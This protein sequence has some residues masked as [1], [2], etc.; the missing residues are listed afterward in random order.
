L[1]TDY[2]NFPK[3]GGKDLQTAATFAQ[4]KKEGGGTA[5]AATTTTSASIPIGISSP[6]LK[7]EIK[8]ELPTVSTTPKPQALP[9][10]QPL[11]F[12]KVNTANNRVPAGTSKP[13]ECP[14]NI[15]LYSNY[16][17]PIILSLSSH[18]SFLCSMFF[19][20]YA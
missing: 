19:H 18:V 2:C 17:L 14:K 4:K 5:A 8:I 3:G 12:P 16:L 15:V 6:F 20:A 10:N 7:Q 13:S 11:R 1:I 9:F